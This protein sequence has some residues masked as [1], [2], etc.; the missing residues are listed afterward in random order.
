MSVSSISLGH[1][2]FVYATF[3]TDEQAAQQSIMD[4]HPTAEP[5]RPVPMT[6]DCFQ[7][8]RQLS[9][10]QN[11]WSTH[12]IVD[13]TA[14]P[15]CVDTPVPGVP[16][17]MMRRVVVPLED[18]ALEAFW[19]AMNGIANGPVIVAGWNMRNTTWPL[20]VTKGLRI[21]KVH[22]AYKTDP[23]SRF[24][25]NKTLMDVH[26]IYMQHAYSALR[27]L[28]ELPDVLNYMRIPWQLA[29]VAHSYSAEKLQDL[30]PVDWQTDGLNYVF[31]LL[32]GMAHMVTTYYE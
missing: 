11:N 2:V 9:W 13:P 21:G 28:P 26:E 4:N 20:L 6:H 22:E 18:M 19:S 25:T 32:A 31:N 24:S 29:P 23:L 12:I 3:K 14:E 5:A 30:T 27:K 7:H 8:L 1:V 15:S 17:N 10:L 16:N